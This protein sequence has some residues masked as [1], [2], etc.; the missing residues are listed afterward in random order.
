MVKDMEINENKLAKIFL[1]AELHLRNEEKQVKGEINVL[2][3]IDFRNLI[4][5]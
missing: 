4:M 1:E 5:N 3:S 2:N